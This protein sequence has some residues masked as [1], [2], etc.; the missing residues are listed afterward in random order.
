[1]HEDDILFGKPRRDL[2]VPKE[3]KVKPPLRY[4]VRLHG[5]KLLRRQSIGESVRQA[6][7]DYFTRHAA[8]PA[9]ANA[10]AAPEAERAPR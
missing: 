5:L 8:A 2:D 9:D 3:L 7:D 1:M 6:L 4:H 10:D